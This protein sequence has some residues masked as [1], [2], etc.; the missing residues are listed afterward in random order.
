[1]LNIGEYRSERDFTARSE[2][3]A[4]RRWFHLCTQ[5][6]FALSGDLHL[7]EIPSW[8]SLVSGSETETAET[9]ATVTETASNLKPSH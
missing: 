2:D 8:L 9:V 6:S 3:A 5:K 7:Q 4:P 1:M